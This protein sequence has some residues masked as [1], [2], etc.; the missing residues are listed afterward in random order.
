MAR[1]LRALAAAL[2]DRGA[3]ELT[4]RASL[5]FGGQ[6]V[7]AILILACTIVLARALGAEQFG[8]YALI[9][10]LVVVVSQ[11]LDARSWEVGTRF[12][13]EHLARGETAMARAAIEMAQV[14]DLAMGVLASGLII[15]LAGPIASVLLGDGGLA[16]AV[17]AYAVAAPFFALQNAAGMAFRLLDEFRRLAVLST[18]SPLLRLVLAVAALAAGAGLTGVM[19]ALAAAEVLGGITFVVAAQRLMSGRLSSH[20]LAARMAATLRELRRGWRVVV[21]SNFQ[22]TLRLANEQLDVVLVGLVA[23]PA[24][25]GTLKMA[26]TFTQ[27]LWMLQ[28]PFIHAV[29]PRLAGA[30]EAGALAAEW[31]LIARLTPLAA[32]V[33]LS[34]AIVAC[35]V[36]PWLIPALAGAAFADSW[37]ALVPIALATATT[38]IAF[39]VYPAALVTGLQHRSVAALALGTV[40]QVGFVVAL[41]PVIGIAAAGLGYALAMAV[42]LAL[43]APAVRRRMIGEGSAAARRLIVIGPTPPPYHGGAVMT[44]RLLAALRERGLLAAHLD[45][46]DQRTLA[47]IGRFDA[48]NV[49]LGLKHSWQFAVLLARNPGAGVHVPISQGRWGFV[50]DAVILLTARLAG[51]RRIVHLHGGYFRTFY[52]DSGGPMQALIRLA[53][54]GVEQAWVLTDGL[55][56]MFDGIVPDERIRVVANSVA[57]PQPSSSAAS[58]DDG[59]EG[60]AARPLQILYFANLYPGKGW[61]EL[62]CAAERL[63]ERE[64]PPPLWI[65][66]A[67][68]VPETIRRSLLQRA[69]RLTASGLRVEVLGITAGAAKLAEFRSADVFVYPS[70]YRYEGQPLVLLEA[71]AAGLPIITCATAGIPDTVVDGA[72]AV[73]IAPG[74]ID[75][76]AGALERAALD[77][78]LRRRLGAAAR[79]RYL[80]RHTPERFAD[81]VEGLVVDGRGPVRSTPPPPDCR[82]RPRPPSPP[83]HRSPPTSAP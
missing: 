73:M 65:R 19:A 56:T 76:L 79:R 9:M 10:A 37:E 3:R 50:R 39:W 82:V 40:L 62:I 4:G 12:A 59:R 69:E 23:T 55:R 11:V 66:V 51:R 64:S 67:G 49:W 28:R 48:R 24:L 20:R 75:G 35:A 72:S 33:L 83:P 32:A 27:P 14:V 63:R 54:A 80:A 77:P 47:S 61:D 42:W 16:G 26:R 43:A 13:S 41:V 74:D 71:M 68:E 57:D 53:L 60:D 44:Q 8:Q 15:A 17:V 45:T 52:R 34:L 36:S 21:A 31:R 30:K 25:A 58:A 46:R 78:E 29:Y 7:A 2:D 70:S 81:R 1:R 38:G 18:V 22:G 5:L 6:V